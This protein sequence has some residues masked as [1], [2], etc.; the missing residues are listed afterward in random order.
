MDFFYDLPLFVCEVGGVDFARS[1]DSGVH[2]MYIRGYGQ[3]LFLVIVIF[4]KE[5]E[6]T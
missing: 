3:D 1:S 6:M 2:Y 5:T 4:Q